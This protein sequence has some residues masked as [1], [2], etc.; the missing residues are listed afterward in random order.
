MPIFLVS[1][2]L[3]PM[4]YM[5][6]VMVK[7]ICINFFFKTK[8]I[9]SKKCKVLVFF[10]CSDGFIG[11]VDLTSGLKKAWLGVHILVRGIFASLLPL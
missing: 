4:V 3:D 11:P 9:E 10:L 1:Q 2:P 8:S 5:F 7:I 6:R